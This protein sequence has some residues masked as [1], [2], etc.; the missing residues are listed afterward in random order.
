M[1][2]GGAALDHGRTKLLVGVLG[3]VVMVTVRHG[4]HARGVVVAEVLVMLHAMHACGVK[5]DTI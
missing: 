4:I 3:V 1:M 2:F 5:V